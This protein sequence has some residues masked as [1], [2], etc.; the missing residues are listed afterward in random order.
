MYFEYYPFAPFFT[1]R[2]TRSLN[3]K[4]YSVTC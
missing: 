2:E 1:M 3:I 4:K